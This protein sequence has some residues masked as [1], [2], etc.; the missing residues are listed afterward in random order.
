MSTALTK[1]SETG[2]LQE[3]IKQP[4]FA[5]RFAELFRDRAP[6]FASSLI[7]VGN[8]LPGVEPTSIITAAMT[9]TALDL[10]IDRNLGFAWIVPYK[11][12]DRKLAQFQM[13]WKGYVQLAL[14]TNQYRIINSVEVYEGELVDYDKLTGAL[15]L[16]PAARTSDT[17]IGYAA[18]MELV[19][20][21]VHTEYWTAAEVRAHAQRYSQ[22]YRSGYDSPWKS[23]FDEMA[24]KTIVSAMLRKWGPMSLSTQRAYRNDGAVVV[25]ID[26][27]PIFPD[28]GTSG[29]ADN[30]AAPTPSKPRGRKPAAI[31][32][33][34]T[35]PVQSQPQGDA[36]PEP[37]L[38]EDGGE[39]EAVTTAA[40]QPA[41]AAKPTPPPA[42]MEA[43]APAAPPPQ[44]AEPK[45]PKAPT[46]P[47]PAEEGQADQQADKLALI[48]QL[49]E[50]GKVIT[51]DNLI[52]WTV[53]SG[54]NLKYNLATEN[55]KSWDDVPAEYMSMLYRSPKAVINMRLIFLND[56]D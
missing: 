25:D 24:M 19:S 47:P 38:P 13:G 6:Q 37:D 2:S 17:I 14:R 21:F 52:R 27:E 26:A 29:E 34:T 41:N 35:P 4:R 40:P 8:S 43:A 23:N 33:A 28:N 49:N 5:N 48:A 54:R 36:H 11:S 31:S 32:T 20:G 44:K 12:G 1:P 39:V 10:P 9:A 45:K 15:T 53:D 30:P 56:A 16:D 22:S 46:P 3:L 7:Q 51:L 18:Y 42:N 55:W 50:P